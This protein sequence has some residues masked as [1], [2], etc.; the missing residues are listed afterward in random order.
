M[1]RKE[2]LDRF[3]FVHKCAGCREILPYERV[4]RAFCTEC[5]STWLK[6]KTENCPNCFRAVTECTCSPKRLRGV[7]SLRKLVFYHPKKFSEPQNQ[8]IYRLKHR[9]SKRIAAFVASEL[10]SA[11]EEE[12]NACG[13]SDRRDEICIVNLP[14]GRRAQNLYGFDQSA[15]ICRALS[16]KTGLAYVEAI[17]RHRGGREQKKLTGERRFA[18]VKGLFYL[19]DESAIRGKCI[20]LLDDIVTTGAS[21]SGCVKLL[22]EAGAEEILAF[23]IAQD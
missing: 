19:R 7:R 15:L 12:L 1:D 17:G 11:V 20:L 16:E 13:W 6:A 3:I 14:R 23:C 18:N 2:F 21:M 9:P 4:S 5:E 10:S 8:M 22:K